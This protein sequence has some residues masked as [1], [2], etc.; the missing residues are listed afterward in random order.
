MCSRYY[1]SHK[2]YD[3][4]PAFLISAD[5]RRYVGDVRPSDKA[6]IIRRGRGGMEPCELS[7]GYPSKNNVGLVINARA[8]SLHEKP[9]FCDDV[10]NR[11]C[12]VPA[13]GFYEWDKKKQKA[14][15]SIPDEPVIYFAGIYGLHSGLEQFVIITREASEDMRRIHDRM[16]LIVP[17]KKMEE[18]FSDEYRNILKAEAVPLD[19]KIENEQLSFI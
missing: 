17:G 12:L 19:I 14:A 9:L 8:E 11:R 6:L 13:S 16:P 15:I 10:M 5:S 4:L 3:S 7:W 2:M 18:W 1:I